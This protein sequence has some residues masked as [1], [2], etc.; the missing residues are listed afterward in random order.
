MTA[1]DLAVLIGAIVLLGGLGWFFLAPRR[2]TQALSQGGEQSIDIIVKGGYSPDTIQATVGVPL[3]IT[4]DRQES[5]SCTEKVIIPA[6]RIAADLP[7]N[8]RTTIVLTPDT[9]GTYEFACGMNIVHGKLIIS[10]ADTRV[11]RRENLQD[12]GWAFVQLTYPSVML[13]PRNQGTVSRL[14]RLLGLS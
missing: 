9:P 13:H 6:F 14:R 11:T 2:A 4:F 7:A 10:A 8:R 5:G 3:R 12:D 1:S